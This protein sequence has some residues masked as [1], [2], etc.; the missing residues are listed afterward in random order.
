MT[1][2][3]GAVADVPSEP[4][5]ERDAPGMTNAAEVSI[6]LRAQADR[7]EFEPLYRRYYP[8]ISMFCRRRLDDQEEAADATSQ[9]FIKAL[10][11]LHGFTGGAVAPWLFTI[12]RHVVI[13]IVRSRRPH[14]DL[15]AM[16]ELVE[17]AAGPQAQ[18]IE[19]DQRRALRGAMAQLTSEQREVVELRLAGLSGQE[20]ADVL[21]LS[22]AAVKSS[23]FR[24]YTRLRTLLAGEHIFGESP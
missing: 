21:G 23:Q 11:G 13:D 6:L 22:L 19:R 7:R 2:W 1:V 16:G 20:I 12:A 15:E 10:A 9:T 8:R 4:S 5:D 18:A 14:V 3:Q 17:T 24:A